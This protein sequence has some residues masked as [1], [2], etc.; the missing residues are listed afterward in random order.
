MIIYDE[1]VSNFINQCLNPGPQTIGDILAEL[2]RFKAGMGVST[3]EVDSWNHSLPEVAKA[4]QLTKIDNDCGVGVEYK[5]RLGKGRI[6]CL[7]YGVDDKGKKNLVVI[8]L[9]QWSSVNKSGKPNHVFAVVGKGGPQDKCHPSIQA[10]GYV[11]QLKNY[12]KYVQ[13][14]NLE[15]H[16]CSYLHN[17]PQINEILLLDSSLFPIVTTSPAF[18]HN[19]INKLINFI[20]KYIKKPCNEILYQIDHCD[21]KPSAH[22]SKALKEA[23]E[24]NDFF[25]YDEDQENAISEILYQ[26]TDS[27]YYDDKR[28]IIIKGG[29]GTGKS[30]VAM[31]VLGKLI[32]P[33]KGKKYNAAYFAVNSAIRTLYG[34]ELVKDDYKRNFLKN[35]F[36]YPTC[37]KD[38][39]A[40]EF[41][42]GIFDESHRL[43]DFKGGVGMSKGTHL[44]EKAINACR[45][46]VFFVDGD[47][48][49]TSIDYGTASN[50]KKAAAKLRV[51]VI[52]N[53]DL[54]LTTQFRCI[55]GEEYLAFVRNFLG[56]DNNR[57]I[58]N[59]DK[60]EFKVL[61]TAK[62]VMEIIEQKDIE[63]QEQY[64]KAASKL[65]NDKSIS[66]RCR[67][68]AG[69]THNWVSKGQ[70]RDGDKFDFDLDNHTF[71]AKWNLRCAKYGHN[72]SW[73]DDPLSVHE[74]GCIHT[75]QGLDLNYCGVIIGK[76]LRF[77]K[78]SH[79][80]VFDKTMNART[81]I[82]S[83]I[84]NCD[85][86]TA[87]K[88]I[89]NTYNVL[90]TRG[91]KGTFIYCEDPD[92]QEYLKTHFTV[93]T[94]Y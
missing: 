70:D 59:I 65:V 74:I 12:Y 80:L 92:L 28:I 83:Q 36:K 42:C 48:T 69:Y 19:D 93:N 31:N 62:E 60:Y 1:K 13:D 87:E 56:Y 66:G 9:K 94:S 58:F 40:N 33:K 5:V 17:M 45:V 46:S 29:P 82:A 78:T 57:N 76:D 39:S 43:F 90:L 55:G 71:L 47:Q 73:L 38:A 53:D 51:R 37:L 6:D 26:V 23:I 63:F 24:G 41:D 86:L 11:D 22:L 2:M 20:Q 4:L 77:D 54:V 25:S 34:N 7:I 72:Y 18:L 35:L 75:A 14:E 84:K 85:D 68:V 3:S 52:E 61:D 67:V 16:S 89:R 81:D 49:V 44:L 21:I 32:S 30:V 15:L 88:L 64:C 50:I 91:M 10:N 79:K 8:E 27:L